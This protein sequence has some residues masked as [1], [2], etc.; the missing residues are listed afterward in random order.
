MS[1]TKQK[2]HSGGRGLWWKIPTGILLLLII[3]AAAV[4]MNID[5]IAAHQAN[6]LLNAYLPAGGRADMI[7]ID[8]DEGR[9]HIDGL[10][11]N[12]PEGY[13]NDPLLS[14]K[15][16]TLDIDPVSLLKDE[17]VVE[18][19]TV[20]NLAVTVV[21]N[22]KGQLS[23]LAM[24]PLVDEVTG[25]EDGKVADEPMKLPV[26]RIDAIRIEEVSARLIDEK[27]GKAWTAELN[28]D[29]SM[30][31][32][33]LRDL[34]KQDAL[35]QRIDLALHDLK[36]DQPTGFSST[37][38]LS[39]GKIELTAGDIDLSK[40]RI[41]VKKLSLDT[42]KASIERSG[43]GATNLEYLLSAWL[44]SGLSETESR[45]EP[46]TPAVALPALA[47]EDL[48]LKN[49]TAQVQ[50][51]SEE[52]TWQA[53]FD[54]L[55]IQAGGLAVGDVARREVSLAR[56]EL[57]LHG[58]AVDQPPGYEGDQ[59]AGLE[60]LTVSSGKLDLASDTL[61]IDRIHIQ[62]PSAAV[63]VKKD[64]SSNVKRLV[65]MVTGAGETPA[66]GTP[67]P[68]GRD[69]AGP[70]KQM[71]VITLGQIQVDGGAIEHR[72]DNLVEE[73]LVFRLANIRSEATNVR[74]FGKNTSPEPGAASVALEL[75]QPNGLPD[76]HIGA[77]AKIGPLG[78]AVPPANAQMR[79]TGFKLDTVGSLVPPGT[80]TTLGADGGD[81]G[82]SLALNAAAIDLEAA[83]LSDR[84]IRYDAIRV[85]GPLTS[86]HVEVGKI[87][88][89]MTGRVTRGLAN[90][91][92]SGFQAG[93]EL[94]EGS[95]DVVKELGVGTLKVGKNL[96]ESFFEIGKG[97]LTF[98]SEELG[99]GLSGS[100]VDTFSLAADSVGEAGKDV[101]DGVSASVSDLKGDEMLQA[102]DTTIP[103][104]HEAAMRQA[105][106]ALKNMPYPPEI[107]HASMKTEKE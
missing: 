91:G 24:L 32:L 88:A 85:Q 40:S 67:A 69:S 19:I 60:L 66:D 54:R 82:L 50:D 11:I 62:G 76:A 107:D 31:G 94:V 5:S 92:V 4:I 29:L 87:L 93:G 37:P 89:G 71:P 21:R 73:T 22:Q 79:I 51:L 15:T 14:L 36:V 49:I 35:I 103:Q 75:K 56:F 48:E 12:A 39:L 68:E 28:L 33:L 45:L 86:P 18:Q 97:L 9:I 78:D 17:I 10:S 25:P 102:W 84:N 58:M 64:G 38:M 77:L 27:V 42:L 105:G 43:T 65:E 53:G 70:G 3:V 61:T 46:P 63:Q 81:L 74:L 99:E 100:T 1:D 72:T 52:K 8:L 23:L 41:P 6:R 98:D 30:G 106:E 20:Q 13:G 57:G 16:F 47:V 83:V 80:R 7:D 55:D 90:L 95:V 44:P 59:L 26:V 34:F 96:G 101:G 104:R 2:K